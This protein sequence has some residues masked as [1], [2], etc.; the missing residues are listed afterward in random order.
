[1]MIEAFPKNSGTETEVPVVV[2]Y[3]VPVKEFPMYE[4]ETF[5]EVK[6]FAVPTVPAYS[7]PC[8][9]TMIASVPNSFAL[10]AANATTPLRRIGAVVASR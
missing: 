6:E 4:P 8:C 1:M 10:R 5:A 9:N 2:A 3:P 7:V